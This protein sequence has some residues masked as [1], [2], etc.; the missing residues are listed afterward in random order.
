MDDVAVVTEYDDSG[1]DDDGNIVA[2]AANG[3]VT[4]AT[5]ATN[6]TVSGKHRREIN[7]KV[8]L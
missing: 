7:K 2:E 4:S 3:N 6:G 8:R 5:T 1:H